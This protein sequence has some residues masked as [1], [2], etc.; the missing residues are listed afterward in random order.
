M[1][2]NPV[3]GVIDF[4]SLVSVNFVLCYNI[5]SFC[6]TQVNKTVYEFC[7]YF[8]QRVSTIRGASLETTGIL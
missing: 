4:I 8:L 3:T 6:K 1:K 5:G 7:L 2:V